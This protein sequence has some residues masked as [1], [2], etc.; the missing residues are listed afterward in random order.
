MKEFIAERVRPVSFLA[1]SACGCSQTWRSR[2]TIGAGSRKICPAGGGLKR[3]VQGVFHI[4][5]L[6]GDH[7]SL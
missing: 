5:S 6:A 3:R 2:S 7:A 4:N 1:L